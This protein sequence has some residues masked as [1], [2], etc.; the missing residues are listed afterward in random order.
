MQY[1]LENLLILVFYTLI[2]LAVICIWPDAVAHFGH[3]LGKIIIG[4]LTERVS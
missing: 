4:W 3:W 2:I 1:T